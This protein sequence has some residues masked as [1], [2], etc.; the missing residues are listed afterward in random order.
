V[1]KITSATQ[2]RNGYAGLDVS[3]TL[4]GN[5]F[6]SYIDFATN[7]PGGAILSVA[8]QQA[9]QPSFQTSEGV[10]PVG[11]P[12]RGKEI[13]LTIEQKAELIK[14]AAPFLCPQCRRS[15][16]LRYCQCQ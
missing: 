13:S 9:Y 12:F 7:I 4:D 2:D 6:F 16:P 1:L 10:K 15:K 8:D 3:G 14:A 11:A 5:S